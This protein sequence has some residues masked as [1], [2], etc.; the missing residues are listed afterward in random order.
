MFLT[1]SVQILVFYLF[2]FKFVFIST[3]FI[4]TIYEF[5]NLL[6]LATDKEAGGLKI[7]KESSEFVN[8]INSI[9]RCV[10][11]KTDVYFLVKHMFVLKKYK[12]RFQKWFKK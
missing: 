2:K 3:L 11:S 5:I 1:I 4:F 12:I 6:M 10:F 8:N 7:S 9:K